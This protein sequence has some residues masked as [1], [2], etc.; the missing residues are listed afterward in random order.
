M[1]NKKLKTIDKVHWN[2]RLFGYLLFGLIS[3][4]AISHSMVLDNIIDKLEQQEPAV[5]IINFTKT[6]ELINNNCGSV[7]FTK[8]YGNE[9]FTIYRS[10]CKIGGY[11][12]PGYKTIESC[13]DDALVSGEE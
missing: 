9:H 6:L 7:F 4:L 13:L 1:A 5:D 10:D 8:Q 3:V 2:V 12:K 11:C